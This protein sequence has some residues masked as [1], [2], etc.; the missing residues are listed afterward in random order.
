MLHFLGLAA[1]LLAAFVLWLLADGV[2]TMQARRHMEAKR[3][4]ARTPLKLLVK[5]R[6][7][8]TPGLFR[9]TLARADGRKL[10]RFRAGQ[11]LTVHTPAGTRRYSLA[12]WTPQPKEYC[13]IIRKVVGGRVSTWLYEHAQLGSEVEALPPAGDFVL[14][15]GIGETVLVGGGVGFTPLAAM[16]EALARKPAGRVW[17]FHTARHRAE[18]IG[19][20]HYAQLD[21]TTHWFRYRPCLSRPDPDWTGLRGRL[22]AADL[23]RELTGT[24][25][26]AHYY[27][28]ARREMMDELAAGLAAQG[29]PENRIHRESFGGPCNTDHGEY[30]VSVAGYGTYIFRGEP[31]LL[32]ALEAWGVP[33]Q[34]D[35]RAGECRACRLQLRQGNVRLCQEIRFD[36]PAGE[37]MACCARPSSDLEIALPTSDH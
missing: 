7:D 20:E 29:V 2:L 22:T 19:Y 14:Q 35:C 9:L 12:A 37:I 36:P 32:H 3:R 11:Y 15:P 30:R 6:E 21:R 25:T 28:C 8:I 33:I 27:L 26:A 16:V 1:A 23:M 34:A 5:A 10:P 4:A 13:L 31:S 18:L 17:L 24:T